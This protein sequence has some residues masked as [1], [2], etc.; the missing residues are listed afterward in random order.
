MN[1]RTVCFLHNTSDALRVL[2]SHRF[3]NVDRKAEPRK[4]KCILYGGGGECKP[5][6]VQREEP[7]SRPFHHLYKDGNRA[8]PIEAKDA[9]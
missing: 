8:S 9:N 6:L 2:Q 7:E 4:T 3:R 1:I 5:L